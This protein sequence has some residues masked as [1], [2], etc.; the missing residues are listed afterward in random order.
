[1]TK[2]YTRQSKELNPRY[3]PQSQSVVGKT[4]VKNEADG[5]VFRESKWDSL[6][7]FIVLGSESG[8]YY[9]GEQKFTKDNANNVL[10]CIKED[11]KRVVDMVVGISSNYLAPKN[12]P[13]EFVLALAVG[14]GDESVRK[15]ALDRLNKVARIGTHLFNFANHVNQFRGWGPSLRKAI[16]KWY[17]NKDASNL[18][19]QLV[20]YQGRNGWTH[21]D[22]IRLS[23]PKTSDVNKNLALRWAVKGSDDGTKMYNRVKLGNIYGYEMIKRAENE[24]KVISL[25]N[26]YEFPLEM[27]PTEKRSAKVWDAVL[28]NLG[29]IALIRNL[30]NLSKHGVLTATSEGTRYV[31]GKL[32]DEKF[33][34]KVHPFA[35]LNALNTYSSGHG[36]RGNSSWNVVSRIT[37]VL[38]E[39]FYLSFKNIRPTG[40]RVLFGLDVS[41]SMIGNMIAGSNVDARKGSAAMAMATARVESDYEIVGFTASQG[42]FNNAWDST[43]NKRYGDNWSWRGRLGVTPLD[44]SPRRRLDDV[45]NH[46]DR[47]PFGA[48]DCA[49]PMLYAMDTNKKFDAFVIYTDNES[50][51]GDIH[52]FQALKMYREKTGIP[53][54][55]VVV[56]MTST[57]YSIADPSDNGMLD[58]VGFDAS[59]P[60]V[61]SDFIRGDS[62]GE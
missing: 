34:T 7:R 18:A 17:L 57:Q 1:M 58:V 14:F 42:G 61:I 24:K 37:D 16:S 5:Y 43:N 32:R 10:E 11:G 6:R 52:A 25:I 30:G 21:R 60:N 26:K 40:A 22:L 36:F 39:A 47:V 55:L 4:Q 51:E 8:T 13:A 20:K 27:V 44:I 56:A 29:A 59:A 15:Y 49:L 50:W 9:V 35:V 45:V 28:P 3:T 19:F 33:L 31:V 46:M 23:H 38:D 48:T 12:D 54:K 41:S 53:A 62:F 2:T